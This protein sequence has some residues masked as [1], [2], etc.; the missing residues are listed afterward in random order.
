MGLVGLCSPVES[1]GQR[2]DELINSAAKAMTDAGIDV[3][4]ANRSVWNSTDALNVCDQFKAEGIE[5]VAIM[6]VTWV[7]G[8]S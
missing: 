6:D 4:V 7:T 8:F 2:Y 3:V 1:G 5:S